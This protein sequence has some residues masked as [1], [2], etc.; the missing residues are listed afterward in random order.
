[1]RTIEEEGG[2]HGGA[3][4]IPDGDAPD[5]PPPGDDGDDGGGSGG[6]GGSG[7]PP[8]SARVVAD[9]ALAGLDLPSP[10][11]HHAPGDPTWVNVD[12]WLWLGSGEWQTVRSAESVRGV[13][14]YVTARPSRVVWR[15][16]ERF[17]DGSQGS[18]VCRGPGKAWPKGSADDS[19]KTYCSYSYRSTSAKQSDE[20]YRISATIVWDVS[21]TCTGQCDVG[22]SSLTQTTSSTGRLRV[23]ER[24][25]VVDG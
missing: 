8:P 17:S 11:I 18:T 6:S 3:Y 12:T 20:A 22:G 14:V 7:S 19:L 9:S 4:Q 2:L 13:S 1:M 21:W 5:L 15:M 24:Q 16:G 10:S 23:G 25:A